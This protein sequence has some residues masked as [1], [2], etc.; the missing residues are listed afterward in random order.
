[1][2]RVEPPPR[3]ARLRPVAQVPA[4]REI[5]AE[6]AAPRLRQREEHGLVRLRPGV[7]LHVDIL[8]AE[9][10]PGAL[11]RQA[12]DH[13]DIAPAAV[14]PPARVAFQRL[15]GDLVPEGLTH[16]SADD[17]FRCDQLDLDRLTLA[18]AFERS[19]DLAVGIGERCGA[20]VHGVLLN[21]GVTEHGDQTA[22]LGFAARRA[23]AT[24]ADLP[25]AR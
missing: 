18:F 1:M 7:R 21:D 25:T 17:V 16:R 2:V 9:Q 10:L 22:L 12:L 6:N 24:M 3:H 20:S 13:V 4:G 15:V 23:A 19:V 5:H 8:G 11:N 14:K